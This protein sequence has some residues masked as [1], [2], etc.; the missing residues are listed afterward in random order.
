M[1]KL[2]T[3]L[4]SL[5][6]VHSVCAQEAVEAYAKDENTYLKFTKEAYDPSKTYTVIRFYPQG[7][8][9]A[10][11]EVPSRTLDVVDCEWKTQDDL[12]KVLTQYRIK[13]SM[14]SG[15]LL[16]LD[17]PDYTFNTT[18]EHAYLVFLDNKIQVVCCG[19]GC[20]KRLSGFFAVIK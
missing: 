6:I 8:Q 16:R 1:N 17:G 2:L 18:S 9:P 20:R 13:A 12:D 14:S 4:V 19:E 7:K 11:F 15:N 10:A 3:I 5:L